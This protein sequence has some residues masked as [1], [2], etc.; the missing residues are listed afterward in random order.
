MPV[1]A[2]AAAA[3][4]VV[5][6]L[7]AGDELR[8]KGSSAFEIYSTSPEGPVLLGQRCRPGDSLQAEYRSDR[9]YLLVVGVDPDDRAR[10][11]LPLDGATSMR[12]TAGNQLAPSSWV[13]D[14][15]PGRERFVAFFSDAPISAA[16]AHRTAMA[17]QPSLASTTVV[18]RE[19]VKGT[20]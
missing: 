13:L 7:P 18:V 14:E 8:A 17:G 6:A 9:P 15:Q 20:P 12:I 5:W 4:F 1:L 10:T 19:C 11:L 3:L 16:V 2:T